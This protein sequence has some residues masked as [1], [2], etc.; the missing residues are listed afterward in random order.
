MEIKTFKYN[1]EQCDFHCNA[2]SIWTTH[3]NREKHKTGKNKTRTD[4][5]DPLQCDKCDYITK[6]K[7]TMLQHVLNEHSDK[8]EREIKFK[9]YCKIC[10]VGSF[11]IDLFNLHNNCKKHKSN[12][13]INKC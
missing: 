6:N 12:I 11:S 4:K 3:I 8:K 1:C 13:L 10:N 7:T 2:E 9:F 5:K